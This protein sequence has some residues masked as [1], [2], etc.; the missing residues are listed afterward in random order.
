ML[1]IVISKKANFMETALNLN[2][3]GVEDNSIVAT[4]VQPSTGLEKTF[5]QAVCPHACVV[6][7]FGF[8]GEVRDNFIESPGIDVL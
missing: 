6:D 1:F 8:V 4:E 3:F 7:A 5:L 2:Y